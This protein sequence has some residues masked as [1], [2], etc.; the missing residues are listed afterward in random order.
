MSKT[1]IQAKGFFHLQ[2][3][4]DGKIVG[5]SGWQENQVTNL[6]FLN[7]LVLLLGASAGSAQIGYVALGTGGAPNATALTLPGEIMSSTERKAVTFASVSSTTAQF[8]ATFASSDSF[9]SADAAI[10]N[11]G[12]YALTTTDDQLF[13]G[14]VYSSSTLGTNQ[15]VNITYQIRFS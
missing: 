1:A 7:Y 12:L 15:N 10:S 13:A 3:E 14:N 9:N 8:T 2:I 11:I 4:E 6:G 5:D